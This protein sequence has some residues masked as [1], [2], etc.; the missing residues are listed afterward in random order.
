VGKEAPEQGGAVD[1][2]R[3]VREGDDVTRSRNV[4]EKPGEAPNSPQNPDVRPMTEDDRRNN[5]Y[6]PDDREVAAVANVH[7]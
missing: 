2:Y 1:I 5:T 7:G 6:T 3:F 4:S